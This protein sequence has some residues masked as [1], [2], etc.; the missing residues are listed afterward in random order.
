[1]AL[2]STLLNILVGP[3]RTLRLDKVDVGQ[4]MKVSYAVPTG[5]KLS[6]F[7]ITSYSTTNGRKVSIEATEIQTGR[8]FTGMYFACERK[9]V[10]SYH[11]ELSAILLYGNDIFPREKLETLSKMEGQSV[12]IRMRGRAGLLPD[13]L[14]HHILK[15]YDRR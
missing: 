5:G 15:N 7:D 9:P 10:A 1:M 3:E 12:K 8:T 13:Y 4:E 2:A 6:P 11:D 14:V